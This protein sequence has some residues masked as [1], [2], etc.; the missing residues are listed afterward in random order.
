MSDDYKVKYSVPNS[1]KEEGTLTNL[2]NLQS[3]DE[4]NKSEFEGFLRSERIMIETLS[5]GTIFEI[6]PLLP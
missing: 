1:Q 2:L 5:T 4:I 3:E 6:T